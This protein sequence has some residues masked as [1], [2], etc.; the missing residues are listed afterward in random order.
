MSEYFLRI[1]VEDLKSFERSSTR[2]SDVRL[3]LFENFAQVDL[4]A[5]DGLSL[6]F[7]DTERKRTMH[8]SDV[9]P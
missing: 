1:K 9:Y 4:D 5:R 6:R 3:S 2:E 8:I 7:V